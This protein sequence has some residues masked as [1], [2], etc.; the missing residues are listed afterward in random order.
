MQ[1]DLTIPTS[2]NPNKVEV[3]VIGTPDAPVFCLMDVCKV[4]GLDQPHRVADRLDDDDRTLSTVADSLGRE[5]QSWFV[6]EAGLYT[7][8]LRSDKPQA[9]PFRKW[10]TGEVLPAIRKFGYYPVP[11]GTP[12]IVPVAEPVDSLDTLLATVQEMVRQKNDLAAVK[13]RQLAHQEALADV[14]HLAHAA[15]DYQQGNFGY[16]A[17]LAFLKVHGLEATYSEASKL[18]IRASRLCRER[19]I[20]IRKMRDP[21]FGEVNLY[22]ESILE[23]A[24]ESLQPAGLASR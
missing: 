7:V 12:A 13:A 16:C 11:L 20:E 10:V 8:L 21:R 17:A 23:E 5:Q 9:R 19:G 3:R 18:G 24:W 15:L 22:P 14:K 1:F 2:L 4:L 6:T